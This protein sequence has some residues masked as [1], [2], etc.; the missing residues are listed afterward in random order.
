M[1]GECTP[2]DEVVEFLVVA[3][4]ADRFARD[5]GW[6]DRF[7]GFLRAG[8]FRFECADVAVFNAVEPLDVIGASGNCLS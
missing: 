7:V 4:A 5:V 2:A 6:T 1:A 3:V 8:R